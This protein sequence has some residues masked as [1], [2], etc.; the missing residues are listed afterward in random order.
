M[1][2]VITAS[3]PLHHYQGADNSGEPELFPSLDR[4]YK[5][6]VATAYETFSFGTSAV[7]GRILSD[8]QIEDA[9]SWMESNPPKYIKLP[10]S[11]PAIGDVRNT[12]IAYRKQGA[13]EDKTNDSKSEPKAAVTATFY[14]EF[15][16]WSIAW[17]WGSEPSPDTRKTLTLLAAEVPYLG[18]ASSPVQLS[19]ESA[20][21]E[22]PIQGSYE[23]ASD[24]FSFNSDIEFQTP[25]KGRLSDLQKGYEEA[26]PAEASA[27]VGSNKD[28][29]FLPNALDKTVEA[30][31]YVRPGNHPTDGV[32]SP[33]KRGIV[34]SMMMDDGVGNRE[35]LQ[36][37]YVPL[38]VALHR[39]LVKQWGLGAS[40][41]L[42]GRYA[43]N[44]AVGRPDNNVSIQIITPNLPLNEEQEY[45][46]GPFF[47]LMI[48]E[49]MPASDYNFL[50]EVC[51]SLNGV[52]LYSRGIRK[53][54][55]LGRV[56]V[57]DLWNFWKPTTPGTYRFWV[58]SPLGIYETRPIP[59]F[60]SGRKWTALE[61]VQLSFAHVWRSRYGSGE[62]ATREIQY[63]NLTEKVARDRGIRVLSATTEFRTNMQNFSHHRDSSNTLRGFS[64]VIDFKSPRLEQAALAIGQSRHLG[65]GFLVPLDLPTTVLNEKKEPPW[66]K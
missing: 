16:P 61:A 49:D 41:F 36:S 39:T 65:G 31:G 1:P 34:L 10:A 46:S 13:W 48:P 52:H 25:M 38:A 15:Q 64:A 30:L 56:S 35:P 12:Y 58:P 43:K 4:L 20:P 32:V 59:D 40:P 44:P 22:L 63:W 2:F 18:E 60:D 55:A 54:V 28:K 6:F 53:P 47:L 27:P 24:R 51:T 23:L 42:T 50:K 57:V 17:Q 66:L 5:A 9:L 26:Y 7:P 8:R 21:D 45:P 62:G 33:W 3:F 11:L 29:N 37:E 19:V 14:P